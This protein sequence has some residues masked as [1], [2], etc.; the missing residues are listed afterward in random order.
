M[1]PHGADRSSARKN[2][3][4]KII[5]HRG[6]SHA[7][8]ENTMVSFTAAADAGCDGVELDV[9]RTADGAIVVVH[10]PDLAR[11]TDRSGAVH[12]CTLDEVLAADAGWSF[13]PDG[14]G[15]FPFRGAGVRIPL[16]EEVLDLAD[17]RGF[18]VN[19]EI[20]NLP[21]APG[22]SAQP[23]LALAVAERIIDRAEADR[24]Y[25]SSF[26]L[27]DMTAVRNALPD[28]RASWL[29]LA[30]YDPLL[31]V[32]DAADYGCTGLHPQ[33][34]DLDDRRAGEL[35]RAA[36]AR[37]LFL[38]VWTVDDDEE[39]ER[40]A[41]LGVPAVCTNRVAAARTVADAVR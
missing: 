6:D 13:D 12:E 2:G 29:T 36:A 1:Q 40:C 4:V 5:G 19:C 15:S 24:H 34:H 22:F 28:V 26:N 7:F 35:V 37:D 20:K 21:G 41:R 18:T 31:A 11:T 39:L 3:P 16:L 25:L 10:D 30:L 17:E 27:G 23:E 38:M 14:D 8:P 32:H 9:H 33:W